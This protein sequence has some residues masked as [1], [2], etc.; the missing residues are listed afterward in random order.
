M[1]NS[2]EPELI[3]SERMIRVEHPGVPC[4]VAP[5]TGHNWGMETPD[6]FTTMIRAW[7]EHAPLPVELHQLP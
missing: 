4:V 7:V 2:K 5:G 3:K 6:P 1:E